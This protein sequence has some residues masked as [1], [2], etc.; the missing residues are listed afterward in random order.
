MSL[1][2]TLETAFS[3]LLS[4][5]T[6]TNTEDCK[7]DHGKLAEPDTDHW[8]LW[9]C[10]FSPV[11]QQH[12]GCHQPFS[13]IFHSRTNQKCHKLINHA[14]L[15]TPSKRCATWVPSFPVNVC[16]VF[17]SHHSLQA[18]S[19]MSSQYIYKTCQSNKTQKVWNVTFNFEH[20]FKKVHRHTHTRIG[21][22]Y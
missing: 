22:H 21:L 2:A 13:T 17:A 4:P 16:V 9:V 1:Q 20:F 6:R 8:S 5:S 3:F 10:I 19:N 12:P 14:V 11:E 7:W 15:C 18:P